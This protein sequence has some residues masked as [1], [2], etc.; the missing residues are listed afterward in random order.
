MRRVRISL[1]GVRRTR[2]LRYVFVLLCQTP[3]PFSTVRCFLR[4]TCLCSTSRYLIQDHEENM[5]VIGQPFHHVHL[6][7]THHPCQLGSMAESHAN[8]F[9]L[10]Y[11]P[12]Q[13]HRA[14]R[15]SGAH[16]RLAHNQPIYRLNKMYG[17]GQFADIPLPLY[18]DYKPVADPIDLNSDRVVALAVVRSTGRGTK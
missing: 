17:S 16:E 13:D 7:T 15:Q 5:T 6:T 18:Q 8:F 4:N 10:T 11:A 2:D 14:S 9:G 3:V 1:W 12:R